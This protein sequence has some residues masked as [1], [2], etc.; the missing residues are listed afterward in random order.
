MWYL[1]ML[2]L[3]LNH[4]NK[5]DTSKENMYLQEGQPQQML[6]IVWLMGIIFPLNH[7]DAIQLFK[8]NVI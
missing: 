4:V 3:K 5:R 6:A 2:A 7:D 8:S 1:S